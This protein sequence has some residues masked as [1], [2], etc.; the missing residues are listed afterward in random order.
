[1][2]AALYSVDVIDA[3]DLATLRLAPGT[4]EITN[5]DPAVL[6]M[7]D[8]SVMIAGGI[9]RTTMQPSG[10]VWFVR[11]SIAPLAM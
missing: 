8:G 3:S 9:D 4:R 1:M 10:A 6:G 2:N 5:A 11:G 7:N